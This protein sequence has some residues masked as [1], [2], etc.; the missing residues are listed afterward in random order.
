MA[1]RTRDPQIV[2]IF[3]QALKRVSE[4]NLRQ[5]FG[6]EQEAYDENDVLFQAGIDAASIMAKIPD[7]ESAD[8]SAIAR[9]LAQR[10]RSDQAPSAMDIRR[11]P[12][13]QQARW[14]ALLDWLD[15]NHQNGVSVSLD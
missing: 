8:L 4:G 2:E 12:E 7:E 5:I 13:Y 10:L 14:K 15:E 3:A 6:N 11:V 9:D 1:V